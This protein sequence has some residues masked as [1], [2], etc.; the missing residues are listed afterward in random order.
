MFDFLRRQTALW[1]L[2]IKHSPWAN[3]GGVIGRAVD[4]TSKYLLD[5]YGDNYEVDNT[6]TTFSEAVTHS[7]STNATMTSGYGPELVTNLSLIH[8]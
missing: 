8:I 2:D 5:L 7:A 3:K 1:L 6:P 4:L